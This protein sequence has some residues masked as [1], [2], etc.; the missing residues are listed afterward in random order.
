M[1]WVCGAKSQAW[2]SAS[3]LARLPV[4]VICFSQPMPR[5]FRLSGCSQS[6]DIASY[7]PTWPVKPE[8]YFTVGSWYLEYDSMLAQSH[9]VMATYYFQI[10]FLHIVSIEVLF[11]MYFHSLKVTEIFCLSIAELVYQDNSD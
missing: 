1:L 9:E 10:V 3:Q 8:L 5:L 2:S 4:R 6:T 7:S 11:L